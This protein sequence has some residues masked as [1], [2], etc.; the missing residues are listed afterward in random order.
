[1]TIEQATFLLA[2]LNCTAVPMLLAAHKFMRRVERRL[3]RLERV[4]GL[5]PLHTT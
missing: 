5:D 2:L 4:L 3:D 1:M